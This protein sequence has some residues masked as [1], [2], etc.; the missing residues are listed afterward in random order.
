MVKGRNNRTRPNRKRKSFKRAAMKMPKIAFTAVVKKVRAMP[1]PAQ[2]APWNSLTVQAKLSVTN[3]AA[4]NY[5]VATL[6]TDLKTQLE[7]SQTQAVDIRVRELELW[8]LAAREMEVRCLNPTVS[9]GVAVDPQL[10]T[11][12]KYPSRDGFT[13]TG[14][15]YPEAIVAT[16]VLNQATV[17]LIQGN[18]GVP[19]G[20]TNITT[21]TLLV[22]TK[23]LWRTRQNL[24]SIRLP[25]VMKLADPM[26]MDISN[27][28]N[29][30]TNAV[31]RTTLD[32]GSRRV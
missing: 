32:K 22:R 27:S 29:D 13:A 20:I 15:I 5:S 28:I 21:T 24:P 31:N 6:L 10:A 30:V 25:S 12:I 11:V 18:M 26:G 3:G 19:Y 2:E 8:D 4:F 9:A 1:P 23:V 14:F 7:I 16:P 17:Y